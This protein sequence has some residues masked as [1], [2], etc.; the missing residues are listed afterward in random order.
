MSQS[1]EGKVVWVTGSSRGIGRVVA[2]HLS[3]LGATVAIHGTTPTSSRAFD[4]AD[5]LQA[6]AEQI[7]SNSHNSVVACLL[8]TSPSPRDGLLSRMPACA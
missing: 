6:V 7:S 5:S 8:Y 1:L 4:E 3:S 2:S